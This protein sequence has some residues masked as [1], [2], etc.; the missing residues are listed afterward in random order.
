MAPAQENVSKYPKTLGIIALMAY[1]LLFT[2][3][4]MPDSTPGAQAS[5]N[6]HQV[7]LVADDHS[8]HRRV[9]MG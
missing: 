9:R 5:V 7:P 8:R 3:A 2:F 6:A 4:T 1:F